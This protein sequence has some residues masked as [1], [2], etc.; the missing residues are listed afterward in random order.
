[1]LSPRNSMLAVFGLTPQYDAADV[2]WRRE[3]CAWCSLARCDY[4]RETVETAGD[5]ETVSG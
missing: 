5:S 1:M 2:A 3:R 4:R